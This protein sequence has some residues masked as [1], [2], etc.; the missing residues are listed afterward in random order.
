MPKTQNELRLRL[1]VERLLSGAA[2]R[3]DGRLTLNN[4]AKEAE[5]SRATVYRATALCEEFLSHSQQ[6]REDHERV[7]GYA[8]RLRELKQELAQTV[9]GKNQIIQALQHTVEILAQQVQALTLENAELQT[10]TQQPRDNIT[11]FP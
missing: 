2:T 1:A 7:L 5:L 11:P 3:T 9:R 8:E 4:L 6:K 10:A